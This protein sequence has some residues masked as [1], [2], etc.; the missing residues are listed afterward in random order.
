MTEPDAAARRLKARLGKRFVE[1]LRAFV[2]AEI[3]RLRS[4]LNGA[5]HDYSLQSA[6]DEVDCTYRVPNAGSGN[7]EDDAGRTSKF[8]PCSRR[9]DYEP[10]LL[11]G[12]RCNG[13]RFRARPRDYPL[14]D[15]AMI[16]CGPRG[17][18]LTLPAMKVHGAATH[19]AA[20]GSTRHVEPDQWIDAQPRGRA[21][22]VGNDRA[23]I[24]AGCK[25]R[26]QIQLRRQDRGASRH[27]KKERFDA[28]KP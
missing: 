21:A 17:P 6:R 16:S 24:A 26:F 10:F 13:L 14:G 12:V 18:M 9:S 23:V 5:H 3:T 28:A 8:F 11:D 1:V 22:M 20:P 2:A 27:A 25:T 15:G 4:R 19:G 7:E